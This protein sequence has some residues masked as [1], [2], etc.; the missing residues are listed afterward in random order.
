MEPT[1]Q[2]ALTGSVVA[3]A[4]GGIT[5][6]LLIVGYG[7]TSAEDETPDAARRR[8]FLIRIGHAAA[9][10]C[11][12]VTALLSVVAL[13]SRSAVGDR[14]LSQDVR[15]LEGRIGSIEAKVRDIAR[16]IDAVL[17]RVDRPD[18]GTAARPPAR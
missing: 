8:L 4:L 17:E 6:S 12:A 16:S 2:Y 3:S 14:S 9:A 5:L 13:A 15:A 11:F 7:F 10:V 1:A 18:A